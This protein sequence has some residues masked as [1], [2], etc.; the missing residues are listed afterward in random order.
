[1]ST[2]QYPTDPQ[3]QGSQDPNYPTQPGYP[4]QQ[5][6]P[7]QPSY[8]QQPNYPQPA[9]PSQPL[10]PQYGE[11]QPGYPPPQG[12]GYGAPP[13]QY[14]GQPPYGGPPQP[15]KPNRAPLIIGIV[16]AVVLLCVVLPGALIAISALRLGTNP[17]RI[18]TNVA[19]TQTTQATSDT[20]TVPADLVIYDNPMDGTRIDWSNNDHCA[21]KPDG[22]HITASYVCFAPPRD[23]GDVDVTVTV[24]QISGPT[25]AFFGIAL[26]SSLQVN[27]SYAFEVDAN[28]KWAF[29]VFNGDDATSVVDVTPN[30]AIKTGLGV[31]NVLRVRAVGSHFTFFVN[32]VQVGQADDSTYT[33]GLLGLFGVD[34]MDVAYTNFRATQ[35]S[36]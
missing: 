6:Y 31:T 35:P 34:G 3:G 22:Y 19:A 26:R 16:A 23:V 20:P 33:S 36:A 29:D 14:P 15:P 12:F 28:G 13:S 5:G 25:N 11:Q 18:A 10:Y 27:D 17:Q 8:P 2:P 7:P 1:V 21:F 9:Y 24:K 4:P 32:D 30:A